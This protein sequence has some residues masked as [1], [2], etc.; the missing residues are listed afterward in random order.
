MRVLVIPVHDID[1]AIALV[2]Q[3]HPHAEIF[4][5]RLDY[6]EKIEPDDIRDL[7]AASSLPVIATVRNMD[8]ILK[9]AQARPTYLDLAHDIPSEYINDLKTKYPEIKLIR[10]YHD[11]EKTP[12]RDSLTAILSNMQHPALSHYKIATFANTTVDALRMLLFIK[13]HKFTGLCMGEYGLSTRILSPIVFSEFQYFCLSAEQATAPGQITLDEYIDIYHGHDINPQT[14]IYALLGDPVETSV[15][16]IV[17]NQAF[18]ILKQNAVYVKLKVSEPE[19]EAVLALC[20]RLPFEGFSITMPLKKAMLNHVTQLDIHAQACGA[21][22]TLVKSDGAFVGHNTDGLGAMLALS[23]IKPQQ[24]LVILG[25]GGAAAAI[26]QAACEQGLRVTLVNRTFSRASTLALQLGCDA[27]PLTDIAH[28]TYDILVN[29]IPAS[30]YENSALLDL[31]QIKKPITAMDIVYQP[32]DTPFTL[33]AKTA[34]ATII[35]GYLMFIHQALLQIQ[36][37][38]SPD[39]HHC[40][41]VHIMMHDYF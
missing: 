25:A 4:E 35:P 29:T 34:G 3:P 20:E 14:R 38:F 11:F 41:Q 15:G 32:S 39:E 13:Q 19:L 2:S 18:H 21:I 17:H 5:L 12:D 1:Q 24:H 37:W 28:L 33:I 27:K 26:A 9:V 6:L 10:S 31:I 23:D 8:E 16:H 7:I 36:T 22:N 30:A 40:K